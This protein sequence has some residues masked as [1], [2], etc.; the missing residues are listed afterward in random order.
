[1]EVQDINT[2]GEQNEQGDTAQHVTEAG[3]SPGSDTNEDQVDGP[4][5]SSDDEVIVKIYDDDDDSNRE[6]VACLGRMST[7]Y[8]SDEEVV[9]YLV[10]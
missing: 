9:C 3:P 6:P 4:Q 8:S 10:F 1:M 5:Y 7:H 2:D